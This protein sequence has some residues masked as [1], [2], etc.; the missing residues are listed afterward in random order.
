VENYLSR[1]N[2]F[3]EDE[4]LSVLSTLLNSD[5]GHKAQPLSKP[6]LMAEGRS[7][8]AAGVNTIGFALSATLFYIARDKEVQLFLQTELDVHESH[9]SESAPQQTIAELP[10]LVRFL[11]FP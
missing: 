10:Y 11:V 6:E 9:F 4:D 5:A 3:K 1:R 8:L 7:L 2:E